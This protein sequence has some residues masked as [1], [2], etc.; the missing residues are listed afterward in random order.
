MT[1]D[2]FIIQLHSLSK[3]NNDDE[4][5][6]SC[7]GGSSSNRDD[8][9]IVHSLFDLVDTSTFYKKQNIQDACFLNDYH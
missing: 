5:S 8:T 4:I 3:N 6:S 2:K 1:A 9:T 7:D